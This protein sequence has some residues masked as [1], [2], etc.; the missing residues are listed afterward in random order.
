MRIAG[1][2]TLWRD[3]HAAEVSAKDMADAITLA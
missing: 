1:V 2:L 3:L